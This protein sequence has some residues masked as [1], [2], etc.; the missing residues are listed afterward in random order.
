MGLKSR[1]LIALS[2]LCVSLS[3]SVWAR[4]NSAPAMAS[5]AVR[6]LAQIRSSG[7][8]RVLINESRTSSGEVKEQTIG[9]E[10]MRVRAFVQALNQDAQSGRTIRLQLIPKPKDQLLEA[11]RKGEG[12]IVAPGELMPDK[13]MRGIIAS[14]PLQHAVPL[15]VVARKG[16]RQYRQLSDLSAR[17]F[18][19][20]RGSA[21]VAALDSLNAKLS[22][23]AKSKVSHQ[24]ADPSLAVEDV[25]EMVNAGMFLLT[26]VEQPIAERW[27]KVL[28][29]LRVDRHMVL[30]TDHQRWYVRRGASNLLAR[31]D[32]FARNYRA[33]ADRD[34]N[35]QRLYR[36]MYRLH[37]IKGDVEM[38]R[39]KAVR[40]VLERVARQQN[41]DWSLLAA[42]GYKES[43]L[44]PN[45][46]GGA[47]AVGLMQVT[48][49]AAKAAGVSEYRSLEG[50]VQASAKYLSLIRKQHFASSQISE[51]DRQGFML[52]AYNLGPGR[53]DALR[54]EAKRRGLDS[55]RWYF[56]VE[57]VA[58]EQMGLQVP[59]YVS[60]VNKYQLIYKRD[61]AR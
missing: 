6:D 18:M 37:N 29:N 54:A 34:T 36:R 35:F 41:L 9:V 7:V 14:T 20:P 2:L 49:I 44:N 23:T 55:N 8:L 4:V 10:Y 1:A 28:P 39:L 31:V 33:S 32:R 3:T 59:H 12:D 17:Q 22:Q 48:P 16:N 5:D 26:A 40:P 21:A 24:I 56:Q 46:R 42:I 50:N 47:G 60:S 45:A 51:Q 13:T 11:L 25:L 27:A 58:M 57:R 15:V 61:F 53:V 43:T 38:R 19:L 30:L 52:A